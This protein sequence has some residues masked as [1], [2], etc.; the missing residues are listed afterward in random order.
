MT[1]QKECVTTH[2]LPSTRHLPFPAASVAWTS[3]HPGIQLMTSYLNDPHDF[4]T[5]LKR[6]PHDRIL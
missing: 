1:I 2:A 6:S 3:A 4:A 5:E